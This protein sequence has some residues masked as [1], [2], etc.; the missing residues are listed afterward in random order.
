MLAVDYKLFIVVRVVEKLVRVNLTEDQHVASNHVVVLPL[1]LNL[2]CI[3]G[4][5]P[6]LLQL[7]ICQVLTLP[8]PIEPVVLR[9]CVELYPIV[10]LVPRHAYLFEFV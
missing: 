7:G 1:E 2:A 10:A 4:V 6:K 5:C 9:V 8:H 3:R